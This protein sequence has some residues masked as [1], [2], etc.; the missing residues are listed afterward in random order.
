VQ[1]QDIQ[2]AKYL[3]R[4]LGVFERLAPVG[5]ERDAAGNRQLLFSHYAGL[6]LLS[7]FNLAMQSVA[8]LSVASQFKRVQ[9]L[10]GG[11]RASVG[12]LSESVRVFDPEH[13]K[14]I[15]EQMLADHPQ[16]LV[17]AGPHR[18]IPQSLPDELVEKL[19]AADGSALRS[20]PQIV[21]AISTDANGKW[22]LHV[23]FEPL[24]GT[25]SSVALR[26]DDVGGEHDERAVLAA[27]LVAGKVYIGD[28]GYEKYKLF[29]QI[30]LAKSD[31]VIR[32]QTQRAFDVQEDRD[33]TALATEARVAL[34]QVVRLSP[35]GPSP[36]THAVRRIVINARSQGRVRNDRQPDDTQIVLFTS[37][38]DVPAE[39]IA[40]IYELR[41]SIELFFRWL[42]H[43]LGCRRLI[44]Q[45]EEG[46][47]IQI[48]VALIA[49]LILS[50]LTGGSVGKRAF[51]LICM[52]LQGWADD[53]ELLDG[54]E[55]LR[56]SQKNSKR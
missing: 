6:M 17:G 8:G 20:L 5:T 38:T 31:Y 24:A 35:N 45:K 21:S 41:W 46:I 18:K 29:E 55:R 7:M 16:A 3:R 19:V 2:G 37:L 23:Q 13:L 14:I 34:D 27:N 30:V 40:A 53:D 32:G 44:S 33:I 12:S 1:E 43:L 50:G 52:H 25:P 39:V 42:K 49:A 56:R 10:I 51:D 48:Y 54:L 22:R 11:G 9:K 28:R 15:F 47:T 36:V 4:V 26:P